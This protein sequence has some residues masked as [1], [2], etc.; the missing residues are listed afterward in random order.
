MPSNNTLQ[1]NASVRERMP[2]DTVLKDSLATLLAQRGFRAADIPIGPRPTAD[3][4]V[5]DGTD[6]YVIEVKHRDVVESVADQVHIDPAGRT[7]TTSGILSEA[8]DQLRSSDVDDALKILWIMS[9]PPDR[10]L[11]YRQFESTAYGILIAAGKGTAKPCYY[12][13]HADFYRYRDTLDGIALGTF[14]AMLLNDLSPRYS[15]LKMSRLVTL[16]CGA[17]RDPSAL[18]ATGDAFVV[19]GDVDRTCKSAVID[20]LATQYGVAIGDLVRLTRFAV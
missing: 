17:V 15:R 14:G 4:F 20:Y 11:R 7:N 19:R 8:V 10:D 12:A 3:F 16:F 6:T 18:E 9:P 2:S 1:L 5:R 13:T